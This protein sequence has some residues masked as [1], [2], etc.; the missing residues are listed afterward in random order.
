MRKVQDNS[1][2][3]PLEELVQYTTRMRARLLLSLLGLVFGSSVLFISLF[4]AT[5][6]SSNGGQA[7]SESKLY[8]SH[9]ILPD[10]SLYKVIM[11]MDRL[12]LETA[13]PQEQIFIK[14]EYANRRLDYAK[15]LLAKNESDLALTT[16]LKAQSYLHQAAQDSIDRKASS[17]V[18][19]RVARAVAYHSKEIRE[20]SPKFSDPQRVPLD[21][22]LVEHDA[23][24]A[25]L[26]SQLAEN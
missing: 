17:S 11:A 4:S 26:R 8:F 13:S 23:V 14:V 6:V 5:Q 3:T 12:Q 19:E 25:K 24:I 15:E 18:R 7:A 16:L 22:I 9:K 1:N 10:H 20:L 2:L 21:Q